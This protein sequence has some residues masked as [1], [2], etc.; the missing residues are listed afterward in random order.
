M[1]RYVTSGTSGGTPSATRPFWSVYSAAA[2]GF[3][4]REAAIF[5]TAATAH[6]AQ[7]ARLTTAGTAGAGATEAK[8]DDDTVAAS[9]TAFNTHTADPTIGDKMH[10]MPCGA[11]VG[12]G[13]ILTFYDRGIECPVAVTNGLGI[14]VVTGTPQV[15]DI[16]M[17]WDE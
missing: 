4:L 13:T 17:V 11:A 14:I 12:A 8:Y 16:T 6:R 5:N 7:L 15:S 2:V 1:A 9:A 10:M 3:E